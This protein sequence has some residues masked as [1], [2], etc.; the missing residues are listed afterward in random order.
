MP[1]RFPISAKILLWFVLNLVLLGLVFYALVLAQFGFGQDWLLFSMAKDRIAA[2]SE[3]LV[4]ELG[5]EPVSDWNATIKNFD[6]RYKDRARFLVFDWDGEQLA[7]TPITLPE[8]IGHRVTEGHGPF[9]R[10][11][12]FYGGQDHPPP[13]AHFDE[14]QGHPPRGPHFDEGQNR[15]P[16][17][18][19][20]QFITHTRDP[21]R[22]WVVFPTPIH[23]AGQPFPNLKHMVIVSD[24]LSAGGLFFDI[25]P[26]LNTAAAALFLSVLLW[27]PL[28]RG[29]NRSIAQMTEATRQIASGRF[30][31]RVD[32]RRRDELGTLGRSINQMAARLDGLVAGQKRFLGDVA[33]ELCSPLAKLRVSLAILDQR[34]GQDQKPYLASAE[35]E[36]AH[37]AGL[38][39]ELL[40]FSKASIGAPAA[41]LRPVNLRETVDKAIRREAAGATPVETTIPDDLCVLADAELL[42]RALANLLRNAVR[43]AGE[44]GP[45]TISAQREGT[46]AQVT[47]SDHGPGVPPGELTRIFDPFYRV[48]AS[49]DRTTGGTGLGLAIVKT[50]VDACGGSVACRNR[51][52]SGLEVTIRLQAEACA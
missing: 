29:I 42:S 18:P 26:W 39:N 11:V 36:A 38:V 3:S 1:R 43:Y 52:P 48:D 7:G 21:S 22:Y 5:Q 37:M 47:V 13:E 31:T 14:G 16:P 25:K 15:P 10:E 41:P 28:V 17:G 33:H 27:F 19:R 44:A 30:D 9:P 24:T 50:C 23:Q 6:G 46:Q 8:E 34:T 20:P 12:H 51:E 32:E 40:S 49:R 4:L 2:V 35:D 45:I